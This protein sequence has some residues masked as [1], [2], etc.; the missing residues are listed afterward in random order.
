MQRVRVKV[1]VMSHADFKNDLIG[2]DR[3][4]LATGFMLNSQKR[5]FEHKMTL[6]GRPKKDKGHKAKNLS[7]DLFTIN[8]LTEVRLKNGNQSEFVEKAVMERA[9][10]LSLSCVVNAGK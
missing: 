6:G 3:M 10:K 5:P 9:V 2:V 7:L 8:V 4:D 1:Q